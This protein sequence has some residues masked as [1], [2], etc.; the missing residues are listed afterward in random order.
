MS[1]LDAEPKVPNDDNGKGLRLIG[2][3][4]LIWTAAS[5]IWIPMRLWW[6]NF[7]PILNAVMFAA[8][9]MFLGI[10]FYVGRRT[11]SET[12]LAERTHE[13]MA[14]HEGHQNDEFATGD[15]PGEPPRRV[16]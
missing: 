11:P 7:M 12:V 4:L 16:A 15:G 13:L 5:M 8:G 3:I 14:Q 1:V 10:G 2:W 9:L 6:S